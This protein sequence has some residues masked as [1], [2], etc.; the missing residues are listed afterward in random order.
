MAEKETLDTRYYGMYRAKVEENDETQIPSGGAGVT[1]KKW[2]RIKVRVYP[3][4][5]SDKI[6]VAAL[7][8]AVPAFPLKEGSGEGFGVFSIPRK[9]SMVWVFFEDGDPMCPVYFAEAPDGVHGLPAWRTTNYPDRKGFTLDNGL[10]V[11]VDEKDNTVYLQHPSGGFLK[12]HGTGSN[13]GEI[14][15]EGK[16]NLLLTIDKAGQIVIKGYTDV[17]TPV[18]T[19]KGN[20]EVDPTATGVFT[21]VEGY[22]ITVVKGIVVSIV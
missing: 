5:A 8:W 3:M 16:D 18:Q 6:P 14:E 13:H 9:E 19:N 22:I 12:I 10:I 21:S 2:G 1:P 4:M 11:W 17:D 7:P 20:L 15:I